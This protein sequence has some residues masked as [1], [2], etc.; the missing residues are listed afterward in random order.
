[1]NLTWAFPF[2]FAKKYMKCDLLG[3]KCDRLVPKN[4]QKNPIK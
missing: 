2:L 3:Y 1:M 4:I